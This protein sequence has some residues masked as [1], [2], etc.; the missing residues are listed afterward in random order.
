MGCVESRGFAGQAGCRQARSG[1]AQGP[2]ACWGVLFAAVGTL[3][4]AASPSKPKQQTGRAHLSAQL[5]PG[6]SCVEHQDWH[7]VP[8]MWPSLWDT[9]GK[10][11]DNVEITDS[12]N[13]SRD[14]EMTSQV[15]TPS[16]KTSR[17]GKI[18]LFRLESGQ[19]V[20]FLV[21]CLMGHDAG[22]TPVLRGSQNLGLIVSRGWG[23]ALAVPRAGRCWVPSHS[24]FSEHTSPRAQASLALGSSS[25]RGRLCGLAD[26]TK[27]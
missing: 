2:R 13:E 17:A 18:H 21:P 27:W 25:R 7:L 16:R 22:K 20:E 15:S 24:F 10:K 6:L 23:D 26:T 5:G 11:N 9:H 3:R 4:K 14:Q 12:R 1:L 8:D 19:E